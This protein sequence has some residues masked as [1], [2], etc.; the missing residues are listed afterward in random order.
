M[1]FK[2][3]LR[4]GVGSRAVKFA[5]WQR[6]WQTGWQTSFIICKCLSSN[7]FSKIVTT[8]SANFVCVTGVVCVTGW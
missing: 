8:K 5:S 7:Y 2:A 1:R 3:H 4:A 6:G